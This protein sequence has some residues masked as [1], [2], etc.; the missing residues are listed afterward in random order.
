MRKNQRWPICSPEPSQLLS[1][2]SG[3]KRKKVESILLLFLK[4]L[5][6]YPYLPKSSN[7]VVGDFL[8]WFDVNIG[9]STCLEFVL[10]KIVTQVVEIQFWGCWD[11][12]I[13]RYKFKT[14]LH[15]RRS[16]HSHRGWGLW[17][18]DPWFE[19]V[20]A[21]GTYHQD[22]LHGTRKDLC[23]C[24]QSHTE[25]NRRHPTSETFILPTKDIS[26]WARKW[27]LPK[28]ALRVAFLGM[29]ALI[30]SEFFSPFCTLDCVYLGP[31]CITIVL[32]LLNIALD[33]MLS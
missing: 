26:D 4:H 29:S 13:K 14:F 23:M 2:W 25:E 19:G 16:I 21:F 31:R 33:P 10:F 12:F 7:I 32:I 20:T 18:T 15:V 11:K 24:F 5:F 22:P 28:P 8:I 30:C 17:R 3:N 1:W 9:F 27:C 6:T